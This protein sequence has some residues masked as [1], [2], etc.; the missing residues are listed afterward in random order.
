MLD[1]AAV[2]NYYKYDSGAKE[3]KMIPQNKDFSYIVDAVSMIPQKKGAKL[4]N[5]LWERTV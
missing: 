1:P 5:I 4:D 2:Q 3:F